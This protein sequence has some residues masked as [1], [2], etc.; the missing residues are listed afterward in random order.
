MI[1]TLRILQELSDTNT[2]F[3]NYLRPYQ[4]YFHSGE[5]N[6]TVKDASA[7]I[8]EVK[9][10]YGDAKLSELDGLTVEYK[11]WWFNLRASNTE[12]LVRLNL[13]ARSREIMERKKEELRKILSS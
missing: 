2:P 3:S 4:K 1:V 11:D 8:A 9:E 5:I 7:T 6:F 13:E 10:N 12:P